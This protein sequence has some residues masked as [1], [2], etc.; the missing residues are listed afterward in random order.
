MCI[1]EEDRILKLNYLILLDWSSIPV[2]IDNIYWID[3]IYFMLRIVR[4]HFQDGV[5]VWA[6]NIILSLLPALRIDPDDPFLLSSLALRAIF[7]WC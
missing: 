4:T 2:F 1:I 3:F 7:C 5:L 6:V